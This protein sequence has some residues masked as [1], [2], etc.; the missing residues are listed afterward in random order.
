LDIEGPRRAW[1]KNLLMEL[2]TMHFPYPE[3]GEKNQT[4]AD[5]VGLLH[6]RLEMQLGMKR[7]SMERMPEARRQDKQYGDHPDY[8][9]QSLLIVTA[10]LDALHVAGGNG[11]QAKGRPG[12]Q[13][14][15]LAYQWKDPTEE[16]INFT[17]ILISQ[18]QVIYNNI[19]YW[20]TNNI[21]MIIYKVQQS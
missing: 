16:T 5:F 7:A 8:M 10:A 17:Q 3:H 2:S 19:F 9:F 15:T 12:V 6:T 13:P 4:F 1:E 18:A 14:R 11:L 20:N 21:Y